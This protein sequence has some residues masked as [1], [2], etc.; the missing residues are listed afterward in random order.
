MSWSHLSFF[1][2]LFLRCWSV[3]PQEHWDIIFTIFLCG[4]SRKKNGELERQ[5][6]DN[7]C[8]SISFHSLILSWWPHQPHPW[9]SLLFHFLIMK[10]HFPLLFPTFNSTAWICF[11]TSLS[12]SSSCLGPFPMAHGPVPYT[13]MSVKMKPFS[14][15]IVH[16]YL[17][18]IYTS[19][20]WTWLLHASWFDY[21][22]CR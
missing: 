17:S 16:N 8:E 19:I 6:E 10:I 15:I 21:H 5:L 22:L 1:S 18:L 12:Q 7:W 4:Q 14:D 3:N 9:T 2:D 11:L 20:S 13:P